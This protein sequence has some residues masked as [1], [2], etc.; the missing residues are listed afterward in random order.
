MELMRIIRTQVIRKKVQN[1]RN[2]LG[3]NSAIRKG[4]GTERK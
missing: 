4:I 1:I 3:K 2:S